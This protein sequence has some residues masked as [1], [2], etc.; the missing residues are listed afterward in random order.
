MR[1]RERKSVGGR[2]EEGGIDRCITF[3]F[4]EY[5]SGYFVS[6]FKASIM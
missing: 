2:R 5:L 6:R 3:M 1:E 4:D